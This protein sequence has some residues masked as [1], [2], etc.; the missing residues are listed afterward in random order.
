SRNQHTARTACGDRQQEELAPAQYARPVAGL[1]PSPSR[2]LKS[3]EA[4]RTLSSSGRRCSEDDFVREGLSHFIWR[5]PPA[6]TPQPP[7]GD[8]APAQPA[9]RWAA[10]TFA[11][12]ARAL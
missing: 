12:L 3:G 8:A 2:G 5:A 9:R 6:L 11:E 4:P 1:R 10:S 7:R